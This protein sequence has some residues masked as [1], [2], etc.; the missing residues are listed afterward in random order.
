MTLTLGVVLV[1]DDDDDI[2]AVLRDLLGDQGYLVVEASTGGEAVEF[3]A[4]QQPDLVLLDLGLPDMSGLDVLVELREASSA[5]IIV[6]S[7]RS[8]EA[9][10]VVGLD[11]GAD[12]YVSKP[13][14]AR[15]L[16]ARVN[17][18]MRRRHGIALRGVISSGELV[19]NEITR[20]VA[21]DGQSV[22]LTPKEFDLL[23]FLARTPR[24]VYTRAQLLRHVWASSERWQDDNTVAEHIYRIRRKLDP[25]DRNRWI[26]TVRGVGYRFAGESREA[27]PSES[28]SAA[29]P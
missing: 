9:D 14:S 25:D 11:L 10:R 17:A 29:S 12:D 8:G 18:A 15:E 13:F 1:V 21:V 2:R 4:G 7:G 6:L 20:D 27:T 24:Q 19:I 5:P 22:P 26:E 23:V 28:S 3:C 16:V